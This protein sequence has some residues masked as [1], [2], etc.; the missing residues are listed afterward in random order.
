MSSPTGDDSVV[1]ARSLSLPLLSLSFPLPPVS[2]EF[3]PFQQLFVNNLFTKSNEQGGTDHS[4]G[5]SVALVTGFL[6]LSLSLTPN[7]QGYR[8][9][10]C[11]IRSE[12]TCHLTSLTNDSR[13]KNKTKESISSACGI[14]GRGNVVGFLKLPI[15]VRGRVKGLGRRSRDAL[16]QTGKS[17]R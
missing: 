1:S 14:D 10:R 2:W 15:L 9:L 16:R 13:C 11:R 7:L 8:P 4:V 12:T 3:D 6:S 5:D 17:E